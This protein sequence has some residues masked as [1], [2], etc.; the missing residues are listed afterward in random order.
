MTP[1]ELF[2]TEPPMRIMIGLWS[3]LNHGV[4]VYYLDP[5]TNQVAMIGRVVEIDLHA[6]ASE[7]NGKRRIVLQKTRFKSDFSDVLPHL[8]AAGFEVRLLEEPENVVTDKE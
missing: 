1:S 7:P 8:T 4:G 6:V 3:G 5:T 2:D